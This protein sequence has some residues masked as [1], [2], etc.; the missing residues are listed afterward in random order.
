MKSIFLNHK[1]QVVKL[2]QA[3]NT[4]KEIIEIIGQP[5]SK[6][7]LSLWCKNIIMPSEYK[8]KV[9]ALMLK[10][11]KK[12]LA[13]ALVA[14]KIKRERYLEAVNKRVVHLNNYAQNRDILKIA[15]AML[16]MGEGGKNSKGAIYFGNSSPVIIKLFLHLLRFCYN[17]EE[18]KFRCT[19]Q[20]RADQNIQELERYWSETTC[21]P[22]NLFYKAQVDARTIGKITKKVN[23]KGVCRLNYFS[24]DILN[25]INEVIRILSAWAVSSVG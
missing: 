4:Y 14:N 20:C 18:A 22:R 15:L 12:S 1:E 9:D 16:Y 5:I 11:N 21:I 23:Y 8:A 2:R 6:S 25:E 24:A 17:I 13:T 7:T 3:G 19:V 10:N